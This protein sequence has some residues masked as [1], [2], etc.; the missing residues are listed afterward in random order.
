MAQVIDIEMIANSLFKSLFNVIT[1]TEQNIVVNIFNMKENIKKEIIQKIDNKI[2]D[3]VEN[4]SNGQKDLNKDFLDKIDN[5]FENMYNYFNDKFISLMNIM[6]E[7][8]KSSTKLSM[9]RCKKGRNS[10]LTEYKKYC[11]HERSQGR[12]KC[13]IMIKKE[14][15]ACYVH[16][17]IKPSK[18]YEY[19]NDS[20][21]SSL[22][23]KK[24]FSKISKTIN[25]KSI[26]NKVIIINRIKK[27]L[28]NK[29]K[30]TDIKRISVNLESKVVSD[31][32][33]EKIEKKNNIFNYDYIL[34]NKKGF[35]FKE[36]GIWYTYN[37]YEEKIKANE[38][39][40]IK[41]VYC[42][43]IRYNTNP[44]IFKDCKNRKFGDTEFKIYKEINGKELES[45]YNKNYVNNNVDIN[46][47]ESDNSED[48]LKNDNYNDTI[49]SWL[50]YEGLDDD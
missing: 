44:C 5:K 45:K 36:N 8:N 2:D 34:K 3:L 12:G 10:E 9:K 17:K 48:E 11:G 38:I 15:Y 13:M 41:C 28:K 29:M 26:I 32:V 16:K 1:C 33:D 24:S 43:Y 35:L 25:L 50:E 42:N 20:S 19:I 22:Y 18:S 14:E 49:I 39:K 27:F 4:I 31:F 47:C 37:L 40:G 23:E 7:N 30:K 21:S 6:D 46:K